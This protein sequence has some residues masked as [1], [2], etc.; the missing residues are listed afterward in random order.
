ME[1]SGEVRPDEIKGPSVA[2]LLVNPHVQ[3]H[4][5]SWNHLDLADDASALPVEGG[6][7]NKPIGAR[8]E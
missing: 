6:I 7:E 8:L 1:L 4:R 5:L 2:T 3:R